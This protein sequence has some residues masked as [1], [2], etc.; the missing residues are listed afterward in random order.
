MCTCWACRHTT[1]HKQPDPISLQ[2][3]T[4][5]S[6]LKAILFPSATIEDWK[7][8]SGQ[9]LALSLPRLTG[10]G[11]STVSHIKTENQLLKNRYFQLD[12]FQVPCLETSIRVMAFT[13]IHLKK[14]L[15][16]PKFCLQ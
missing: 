12:D 10:S 16:L 4:H 3:N 7:V 1:E 5:E 13:A 9:E 8:L 6:T 11:Q 2:R 14:S 15:Y